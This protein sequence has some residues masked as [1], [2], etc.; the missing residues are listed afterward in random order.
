M[1][2]LLVLSLPSIMRLDLWDTAKLLLNKQDLL[3]LELSQ[4]TMLLLKRLPDLLHSKQPKLE[5]ELRL[6]PE[7]ELKLKLEP[8]PLGLLLNKGLL[9]KL[10]LLQRLPDL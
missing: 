10:Q 1:S 9:L 8:K 5:L 6:K 2:I 4:L 3:K 7:P